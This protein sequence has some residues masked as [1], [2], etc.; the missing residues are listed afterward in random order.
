[1]TQTAWDAYLTEEDRKILSRGKWGQA[2]EPGR[3]PAIVSIDVQNYMVGRK[4]GP[5][6]DFPYSCGQIGWEAVEASCRLLSAARKRGVPI[7]YTRFALDPSGAE[8]GQF[9][10]KVGMGKGENAFIEGTHGAD[11]VAEAGPRPEDLVITKKKVSAFFGTPLQAYL[12]DLGVDTVIV[13]GGSTSNCVR[14]TVV[15]AS[16]MNYRVLVPREAVFDR[17]PLSHAVSLFDMDRTYANVMPTD[18]VIE[19]LE[20]LPVAA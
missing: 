10:R 2:V 13:I 16:Q 19:Y 14:A 9:A 6:D 20:N 4:G 18:Q 5:D 8:G 17:L 3:R 7:V 15:D 11:F 1:M 12:T